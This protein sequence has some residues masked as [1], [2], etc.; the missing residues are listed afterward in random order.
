MK[1]VCSAIAET[2]GNPPSLEQAK[3]LKVVADPV[4]PQ[5][6]QH[7]SSRMISPNYRNK[8]DGEREA[9]ESPQKVSA[10]FK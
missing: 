1:K 7:W 4:I 3:A 9:V 10:T 2:K 8:K 6:S 5:V